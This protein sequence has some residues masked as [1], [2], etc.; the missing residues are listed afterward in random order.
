LKSLVV[1]AAV[2]VAFTLVVP[3]VSQAATGAH[4]AAVR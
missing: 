3:T 2:V 1:I 4:I